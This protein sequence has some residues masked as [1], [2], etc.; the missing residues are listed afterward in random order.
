MRLCCSPMATSMVRQLWMRPKPLGRKPSI[1]GY[2]FLSE[3]ASFA[4]MVVKTGILWAGP[5]PSAIEA[6]GD[7]VAAKRC[8]DEAGV[9]TLPSS[10]DLDGADN[11]GYP[12]L[13][14]AAAGGGGKGMRVVDS[15]EGLSDTVASAQR[16]AESSF[17]DG[18]VFLERYLPEARHIEIQI[19]GDAHGNLLHLGERE[20][21]IQRRHQKI[22][23]E[24]PSP[25]VDDSLRQAMGAAALSLGRAIG[26]QSA[27]T[28]EFLV[29]EATREFFF[30]EMNTR[31]Q[32]EHR[33]T[34]MV[35]GIDLVR[36]QLRVASGQ[37]LGYSQEDI[38]WSGHAIEA[39]L[40]AEDP[41]NDFLPATGTLAAYRIADTPDVRWDS[42]VDQGSRVGVEFDPMLAKVIAHGPT[43]GEAA[44]R[45]ALALEH[46]HIGGVTTNR[47]FLVAALRSTDFLAGHT[48]TDFIERVALPRNR[49][50]GERELRAVAVAAA[51]WIQSAD[52]QDAATLGF[53]PG[54]WRHG[55]LPAERVEL[56]YGEHMVVVPYRPLRDGS[57]AIGRTTNPLLTSAELSGEAEDSDIP[58]GR[59]VIHQWSRESIDVEWNG[60]R[61]PYRVTAAAG[62]IHLTGAR[63]TVSLAIHPHFVAHDAQQDSG[64]FTAPMPG[65]VLEVRVEAGDHV[66]AGQ[67]LV[68][69]EAMKMEHHVSAPSDG[70]VTDV[71][72]RVG[73]QVENGATLLTF[74]AADDE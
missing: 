15:P 64:G 26:Y 73:D 28:V 67:T 17:G 46:A 45:L 12:I 43:R 1:R 34:E 32:V 6:M 41:A 33:V 56:Q 69:L 37:P 52:R 66:V 21:S 68:V 65:S 55:R 71:L 62:E 47:N 20:C 50:I 8:A 7:K 11:L 13:I 39:R 38:E 9:P 61:Q 72:V 44:G 51:M 31:L 29:D 24:S 70:V 23:E 48:T 2:G 16:E 57:Y 60:H 63:G 54:G 22:I 58:Q 10:L 35:T 25:A 49:E 18:R 14:K 5:S 40:Y 4:Q 59:V 30:L 42:G 74:E 53:I 19:L 3:S 27:G 36:E